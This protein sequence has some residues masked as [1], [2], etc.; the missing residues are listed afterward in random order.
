MCCLRVTPASNHQ[1]HHQHHL[2]EKKHP[3]PSSPLVKMKGSSVFQLLCTVCC[4]TCC[5]KLV[6][7]AEISIEV[8]EESIIPKDNKTNATS[9][10]T[11][12][13]T[14]ITIPPNSQ[15]DDVNPRNL[16][17]SGS[18]SINDEETANIMR[19]LMNS[20]K[21]LSAHVNQTEKAV[22]VDHSVP[23]TT[24]PSTESRITPHEKRIGFA[25]DK[26]TKTVIS[27][28][29]D[30]DTSES[31]SFA[32]FLF[33]PSSQTPAGGIWSHFPATDDESRS[34][35]RF[36][37]GWNNN[38]NNNNEDRG[39][40]YG[41]PSPSS[42]RSILSMS[43][44]GGDVSPSS[45]SFDP[46]V[47]SAA[48]H[49]DHHQYNLNQ[50]QHYSEMN[51]GPLGSGSRSRGPT[52]ATQ[53]GEELGFSAYR[54]PAAGN[55]PHHHP[56]VEDEDTIAPSG[57]ATESLFTSAQESVASGSSSHHIPHHDSSSSQVQQGSSASYHSSSQK[58]MHQESPPYVQQQQ[59]QQQQQG[60]LRKYMGRI[61]RIVKRPGNLMKG[62]FFRKGRKLPNPLKLPSLPF[63]G[64]WKVNKFTPKFRLFGKFRKNKQQ[65]TEDATVTVMPFPG[66]VEPVHAPAFPGLELD[67]NQFVKPDSLPG[68]PGSPDEQK[69][70][71]ALF[72]PKN[73]HLSQMHQFGP[74]LQQSPLMEKNKRPEENTHVNFKPDLH[75]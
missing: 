38:N 6:S 20:M 11:A 18:T 64:L 31:S 29:K 60:F 14:S 37:T 43:G 30:R 33:P 24:V 23:V 61:P 4:L 53:I 59:Q 35:D 71:L 50:D 15:T 45:S 17:S 44:S 57:V 54:M 51:T 46:L 12:P 73:V 2:R 36:I 72:V 65:S 63:R 56:T 9:E 55:L 13:T 66:P 7:T 39:R 10:I 48:E 34:F 25:T 16:T 1:V 41:S 75:L 70:M 27:S 40:S 3:F 47:A 67:L 68:H 52:T 26:D 32:S 58:E 19:D 69:Q 28:E 74:I 5:Q 62:L 49:H 21:E 42:I 22:G 8:F